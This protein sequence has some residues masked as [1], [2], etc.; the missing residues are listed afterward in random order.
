[1]ENHTSP[2]TN[3]IAEYMYLENTKR[4]ERWKT[5]ETM[6]GYGNYNNPTFLQYGWMGEDRHAYL[7]CMKTTREGHYYAINRL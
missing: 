2:S 1:M 6:S 7:F 5:E 3:T 4:V